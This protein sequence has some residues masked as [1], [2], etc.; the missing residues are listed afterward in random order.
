M[1]HNDGGFAVSEANQKERVVM[2]DGHLPDF[3]GKPVL[4]SC[5]NCTHCMDQSDGP[6]YGPQWYACEHPEKGYMSNLKG[7]PFKTQQ[8]C[9]ELHM[10]FTIDW[11]AEAKKQGYA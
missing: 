8:G 9:C 7:F 2:R 3:E 6:E 4:A 10:A 11:E 1:I 5:E